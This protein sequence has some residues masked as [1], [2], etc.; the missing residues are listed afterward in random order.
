MQVFPSV[1]SRAFLKLAESPKASC[2]K[3]MEDSRKVGGFPFEHS[4]ILGQNHVNHMQT[5]HHPHILRRAEH[6]GSNTAY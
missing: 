4:S 3:I 2:G 1:G 6:V 5:F